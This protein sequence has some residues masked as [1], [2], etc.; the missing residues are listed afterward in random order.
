[1]VTRDGSEAVVEI[2]IVVGGLLLGGWAVWVTLRLQRTEARVAAL[3]AR[4]AARAGGAA[5]GAR[6]GAGAGAGG[7]GEDAR[8]AAARKV[9]AALR[10]KR[11]PKKA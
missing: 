11:R 7:R 8:V 1:M 2:A 3:E 6:G 9:L 4:D 5:R 10:Q